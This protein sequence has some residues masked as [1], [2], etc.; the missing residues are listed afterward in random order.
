M[1]VDD[2]HVDGLKVSRNAKN[3]NNP[4]V[5]LSHRH[6]PS[7]TKDMYDHQGELKRGS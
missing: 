1:G 6:N 7:L 3:S 4:K 5:A 2:G